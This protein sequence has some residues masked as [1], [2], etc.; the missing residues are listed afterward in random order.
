MSHFYERYLYWDW[1]G[2]PTG[3]LPPRRRATPDGPHVPLDV[4]LTA[5]ILKGLVVRSP[6]AG[7]VE[8]IP[9]NPNQLAPPGE[10]ALRFPEPLE[11]GGFGGTV[12][13]VIGPKL[14]TGRGGRGL[15]GSSFL[16]LVAVVVTLLLVA[17][18]PFV[19]IH[20]G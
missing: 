5:K 6:H 16:V 13:G 12:L 11:L 18:P 4:P 3:V 9:Q 2:G 19:R 15:V 14:G 20:L 1:G 8:T 17:G 10:D 7:H